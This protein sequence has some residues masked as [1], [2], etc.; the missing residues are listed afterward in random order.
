MHFLFGQL[1]FVDSMAEMFAPLLAGT[2]LWAPPPGLI[3]EKG[4]AGKK[5]KV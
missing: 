1:T 5:D 2:P 4:I 3:K